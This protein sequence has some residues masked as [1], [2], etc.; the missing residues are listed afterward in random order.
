MMSV[1]EVATRLKVS[2]QQVRTLLRKGELDA[3][4]VG[5]QWII[6][7]GA[8]ESYIVENDVV[9]EPDD[10]P[11]QAPRYPMSLRSAFSPVQWV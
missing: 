6:E 3:T 4:M 7:S 2:E 10:H 11:G 8:L 1:K 5:K 9:V